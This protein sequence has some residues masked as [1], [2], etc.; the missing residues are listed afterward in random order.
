MPGATPQLL[1]A[2]FC[3]PI[4]FEHCLLDTSCLLNQAQTKV[5]AARGGP[6]CSFATPK[7]QETIQL[8]QACF[9]MSK[10]VT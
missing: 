7:G 1:L 4:I 8:V 3:V 10:L 6:Y 2:L 5:V 9:A